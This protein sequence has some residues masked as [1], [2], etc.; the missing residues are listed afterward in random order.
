MAMVYVTLLRLL[1]VG[2]IHHGRRRRSRRQLKQTSRQGD[3]AS[4]TLQPNSIMEKRR[5][6]RRSQIWANSNQMA[7]WIRR[8]RQP[9]MFIGGPPS[10]AF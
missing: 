9:L 8:R 7:N 5:C 3:Q 4:Q 10:S 1:V 6:V 2:R